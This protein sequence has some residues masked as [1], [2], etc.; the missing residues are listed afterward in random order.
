[1][2]IDQQL[3]KE[4]KEYIQDKLHQSKKTV[5]IVSS[6]PMN[7]NEIEGLRKQIPFLDGV[8]IVNTVDESILAGVV[9]KFGT[10]MIDLSLKTEL[11]SLKN[12]IYE[13][14]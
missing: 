14:T 10:K 13:R 7:Q 9:I 2:K 5:T 8:R 6:Y 4:L 12:S 11:Q 1:M 3:K